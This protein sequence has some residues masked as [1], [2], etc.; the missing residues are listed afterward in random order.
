MNYKQQQTRMTN[1]V[2]SLEE[3]NINPKDLAW[4][5]GPAFC[6]AMTSINE[7]ELKYKLFYKCL[8]ESTEKAEGAEDYPEFWDIMED[9][10]EAMDEYNK[11]VLAMHELDKFKKTHNKLKKAK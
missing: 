8:D 3:A 9:A 5:V 7:S 2:K 1:L 10:Y 6:E 4:A 11:K